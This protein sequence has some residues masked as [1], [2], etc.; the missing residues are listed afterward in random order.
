MP[1]RVQTCERC[2][3]FK[4]KQGRG[5]EGE[6]RYDTPKVNFNG[7]SVFPSTTTGS[8]CGK[9]KIDLSRYHTSGRK[10]YTRIDTNGIRTKLQGEEWND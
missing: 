9:F 6:C 8:W 4:S 3:F 7:V 10:I 1:D 5:S 2:K